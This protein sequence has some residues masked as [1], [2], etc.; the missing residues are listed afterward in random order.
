MRTMT[1]HTCPHL[2]NCQLYMSRSIWAGSLHWGIVQI[3]FVFCL[4]AEVG[5]LNYFRIKLGSGHCE[6]VIPLTSKPVHI[7]ILGKSEYGMKS[8]SRVCDLVLCLGFQIQIHPSLIKILL[9]KMSI[10]AEEWNKITSVQIWDHIVI[11]YIHTLRTL[12]SF[13]MEK[14]KRI[15]VCVTTTYL[16]VHLTTVI[17][18]RHVPSLI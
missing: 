5:F 10:K 6:L 7:V 8:A 3:R 9:I 13:D 2:F 12:R 1:G 11:F 14:A 16:S 17:I 4:Y 18:C 15:F